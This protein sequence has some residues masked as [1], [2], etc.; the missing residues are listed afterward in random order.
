MTTD[1]AIGCD[2]VVGDDGALAV[3][4]NAA[5]VLPPPELVEDEDTLSPACGQARHRIARR[6]RHNVPHN[7]PDVCLACQCTRLPDLAGCR[8]SSPTAI[9]MRWHLPAPRRCLEDA[10]K[11]MAEPPRRVELE[12]EAGS[13]GQKGCNGG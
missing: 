12:L 3:K 10:R 6:L 11:G 2:M 5:P 13:S 8:Y 9:V 7:R 4:N 1:S